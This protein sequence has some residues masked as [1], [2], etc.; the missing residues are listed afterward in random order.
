M[1]VDYYLDL[2]SIKG[3]SKSRAL[4]IRSSFFPSAGR[5]QVTGIKGTSGS[6]AGKVDLSDFSIMKHLD[7]A[8][9][10]IFAAMCKGTHIDKAS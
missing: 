1:A 7:K 6:G 2:G 5:P 8:T 4:R 9:T 3:E 10:P